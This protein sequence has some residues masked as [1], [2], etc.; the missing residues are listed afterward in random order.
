MAFDEG[1]K[2]AL[3]EALKEGYKLSVSHFRALDRLGYASEAVRSVDRNVLE[4]AGALGEGGLLMVCGD[5]PPHGS[6]ER[7]TPLI[8][9]R[10]P[11]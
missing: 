3:I 7:Y 11:V 9:C 6:R 2:R 1:I 4:V 8:A 10:L 5:R